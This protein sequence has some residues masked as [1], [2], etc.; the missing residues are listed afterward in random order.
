MVSY[1]YL[2]NKII[3][4]IIHG[5]LGDCYEQL[6][7]IKILRH[8]LVNSKWIG[9]FAVKDRMIAMQNYNLDMLDEVYFFTDI[10]NI[11]V[12]TFYQFQID[13][14]ELKSTVIYSLPD[15]VRNKFDFS[16][17]IIPWSIIKNFD[18]SRNG[19]KL[20]ISNI[21]QENLRCCFS[22]N[23][24]DLSIF[25]DKFTVGYLWRY[26]KFGG[27]IK[28]YFQKSIDSILKNK[29]DLFN[30]LISQYNA[31]IIVA[32][33][34]YEEGNEEIRNIRIKGGVVQGEIKSKFSTYKLNIPRKNVTYLKGLG[35]ASEMEIM[36]Y[37]DIIIVMPSGFSEP[38]WM[39][40][41]KPVFLVD[42][43]LHYI[44][45]LYINGMPFFKDNGIWYIISDLI[46]LNNTNIYLNYTKQKMKY[47]SCKA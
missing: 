28:P 41:E 19:L 35:Y 4:T 43:P 6:C 23:N 45:K 33:M 22:A 25:K 17:N 44:M 38:L 26:R 12:D 30:K 20:N 2:E 8:N 11:S 24:I 7:A 13:D 5:A 9:F 46:Y 14:D 21:G 31:H 42:A 39:R 40:R 34:S 27:A 16:H 1:S 3:G 18:Y 47:S 10:V 29:S 32:G 36:S 37:C 15:N